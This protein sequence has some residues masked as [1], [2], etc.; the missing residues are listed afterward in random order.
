MQAIDPNLREFRITFSD[1]EEVELRYTW[2]AIAQIERWLGMPWYLWDPRRHNTIPALVAGGILWHDPQATPEK[3][4][5]RLDLARWAEYRQILDD[6]VVYAHTGKTRA[7]RMV[8]AEAE[9]EKPTGE[10][11]TASP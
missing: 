10:A 3:V 1:G 4:A 7:E 5:E 9:E 2:P 6:A 8:E 11:E